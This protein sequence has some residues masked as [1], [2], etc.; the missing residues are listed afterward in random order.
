MLSGDPVGVGSVLRQ[1]RQRGRKE[2]DL[3]FEVVEHDRPHRH[4]VTGTVFGVATLIT[5]EF[6]PHDGGTLITQTADVTGRG[7]RSLLARVVAKEMHKSVVTGLH[8]LRSRL[9]S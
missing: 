8:Q 9:G 4:S 2:F 3:T 5:V 6:A 7:L 1:H